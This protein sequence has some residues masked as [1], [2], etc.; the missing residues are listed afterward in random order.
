MVVELFIVP[1]KVLRKLKIDRT[2]LQIHLN[3]GK[4]ERKHSGIFSI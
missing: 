1:E 2:I 4:E 3:L